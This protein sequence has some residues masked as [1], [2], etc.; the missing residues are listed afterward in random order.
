MD[1]KLYIDALYDSERACLAKPNQARTWLGQCVRRQASSAKTVLC[2]FRIV[3]SLGNLHFEQ[4]LV[5]LGLQR[6][7]VPHSVTLKQTA[8][9]D[10]LFFPLVKPTINSNA[11]LR[12]R[13]ECVKVYTHLRRDV[14]R[15]VSRQLRSNWSTSR[16]KHSIARSQN[17]TSWSHRQKQGRPGGGRPGVLRQAMKT[18]S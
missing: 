8:Q 4:R 7:L 12:Q 3:A 1:A 9:K 15:I 6:G 18:Q 10:S 17:W 13:T 16:S 2:T 5:A 11:R 14:P